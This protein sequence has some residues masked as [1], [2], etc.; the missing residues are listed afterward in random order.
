MILSWEFPLLQTHSRAESLGGVA[1]SMAGACTQPRAQVGLKEAPP[2][3]CGCVPVSLRA[4]S[5]S[6]FGLQAKN[7]PGNSP[8]QA[9]PGCILQCSAYGEPP[10]PANSTREAASEGNNRKREKLL[11]LECSEPDLHDIQRFVE[12]KG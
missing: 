5:P 12:P 8:I 4:L 3:H 7:P 10:V 6:G 2:Q 9:E 11:Q 1:G